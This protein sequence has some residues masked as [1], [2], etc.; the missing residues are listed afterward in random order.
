MPS[1]LDNV[2]AAMSASAPPRVLNSSRVWL[3]REVAGFAAT[4]PTGPGSWTR[5]LERRLTAHFL[6]TAATKLQIS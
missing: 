4:L 5:D 6:V 3:E 1:L 2:L